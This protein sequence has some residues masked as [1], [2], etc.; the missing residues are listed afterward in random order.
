MDA[1][2]AAVVAA[3]SEAVEFNVEMIDRPQRR[4]TGGCVSLQGK[5][6]LFQS[7]LRSEA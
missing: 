1:V 5:K 3:V 6:T 4:P 7:W 2:F